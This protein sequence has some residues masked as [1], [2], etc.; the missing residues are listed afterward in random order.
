MRGAGIARPDFCAAWRASRGRM[1]RVRS[2]QRHLGNSGRA[3]EDAEAAPRPAHSPRR[4]D[5]AGA[6]EA[7]GTRE[8]AFSIRADFGALHVGKYAERGLAAHGLQKSRY[9][10]PRF[11]SLRLIDFERKWPL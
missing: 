6:S 10:K 11:P 7:D 9:D 5:L 4:G 1:A 2:R 3:H 8:A